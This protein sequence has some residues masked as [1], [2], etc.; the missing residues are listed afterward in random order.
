[1]HRY[2][3]L[4][5]A[6][7]EASVDLHIVKIS[8]LRCAV[9][10]HGAHYI[11]LMQTNCPWQVPLCSE[12]S[13]TTI[14]RTSFY[15]NCP[16]FGCLQPELT[17]V[18][19]QG[20]RP[21]PGNGLRINTKR[22]TGDMDSPRLEGAT[23]SGNFMHTAKAIRY[24][25]CDTDGSCPN[26]LAKP[27]GQG[28]V[29]RQCPTSS[30]DT[31]SMPPPSYT[32]C[33]SKRQCLSASTEGTGTPKPCLSGAHT[34]PAGNVMARVLDAGWEHGEGA[35]GATSAHAPLAP[36]PRMPGNPCGTN[37]NAGS[38][39]HSPQLSPFAPIAARLF[40]TASDIAVTSHAA[41]YHTSS[42]EGEYSMAE[43]PRAGG[44]GSVAVAADASATTG[45][46][47]LAAALTMV[48]MAP[49]TT[50]AL[51]PKPASRPA[52]EGASRASPADSSAPLAA[53]A[54]VA[55]AAVVA[56][57]AT[58][59]TVKHKT[60]IDRRH[61]TA[62][63]LPQRTLHFGGP[64]SA[65]KPPA[66]Q[67]TYTPATSEAP[68]ETPGQ[69]HAQR[70]TP[71]A[72]VEAA[73]AKPTVSSAGGATSCM[74]SNMGSGSPASPGT[75]MLDPKQPPKG[76]AGSPALVPLSKGRRARRTARRM[77]SLYAGHFALLGAVPEHA[78]LPDE[79]REQLVSTAKLPAADES[80]AG[81]KSKQHDIPFPVL[82]RASSTGCTQQAPKALS[83]HQDSTHRQA[84]V[85]QTLLRQQLQ[86]QQQLAVLSAAAATL[87]AQAAQV[88]VGAA[89]ASHMSVS[90]R[91][92]TPMTSLTP[93]I[94][95][96]HLMGAASDG[97]PV[98]NGLAFAEIMKAVADYCA[99]L[100]IAPTPENIQQAHVVVNLLRSSPPQ[101]AAGIMAQLHAVT[102]RKQAAP[103]S[104]SLDV[105]AVA[106]SGNSE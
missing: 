73:S 11:P 90:P 91:S 17:P 56:K 38:T 78:P 35:A 25:T 22:R 19:V 2:A 87:Q 29:A 42:H 8:V 93:T 21:N 12:S 43:G 54:A 1:M 7:D 55:L 40:S 89:H 96:H 61:S 103:A 63:D 85:S 13:T 4:R 27:C 5:Q 66:P 45:V 84:T 81:K 20:R 49:N 33:Q 47:T 41:S 106:S 97:V 99:A 30:R 26:S 79:P 18:T 59:S 105:A 37:P 80:G 10:C 95:V 15:P 100:S 46:S 74:V 36:S 70:A 67:R 52:A 39:S 65:Q 64:G 98:T 101:Q 68:G 62:S 82:R 76:M 44:N 86:R 69:A 9:R 75:H 14:S 104:S 71:T 24:S 83:T 16:C 88:Q 3:L 48:A 50:A 34:P 77:L 60:V 92:V 53:V 94:S 28:S 72:S 31:T 58:P 51:T 57:S 23:S 102:G 32:P 6:A